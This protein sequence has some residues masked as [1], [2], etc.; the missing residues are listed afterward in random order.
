M[1]SEIL[2]PKLETI[3]KFERLKSKI[4]I[5][6]KLGFFSDFVLWYSDLKR[7]K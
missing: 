4:F 6:E 2:N 7:K 3:S 5:I 1:K